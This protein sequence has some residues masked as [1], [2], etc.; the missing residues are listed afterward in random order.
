MNDSICPHWMVFQSSLSLV[1]SMMI[2]DVRH[3]WLWNMDQVIIQ[4]HWQHIVNR[5]KNS[6]SGR[7]GH[8]EASSRSNFANGDLPAGAR[9][10][11]LLASVTLFWALL[12]IGSNR[13]TVAQALRSVL[14]ETESL[15]GQARHCIWPLYAHCG[16]WHGQKSTPFCNF[17]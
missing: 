3:L 9:I 6:S 1:R 13:L 15:R 17:W 7:P 2:Q 5:L 14:G 4:W 11:I 10:L 16:M 8:P 12:W